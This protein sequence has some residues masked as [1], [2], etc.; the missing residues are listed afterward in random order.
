LDI[1]SE[2]LVNQY[3]E[4]IDTRKKYN[5]DLENLKK[6]YHRN[7]KKEY[8][9]ERKKMECT[10]CGTIGCLH[11]IDMCEECNDFDRIENRWWNNSK[12]KEQSKKLKEAYKNKLISKDTFI[13]KRDKLLKKQ[14]RTTR[15][16]KIDVFRRK[17]KTTKE[18]NKT[19]KKYKN[20]LKDYIKN[21]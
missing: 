5:N 15:D 4:Y 17:Q 19:T 7:L 1:K 21:I 13:E 20:D 12:L 3:I 10:Y 14:N 11:F 8:D 18:T 6:E 9:E 2:K 16:Y